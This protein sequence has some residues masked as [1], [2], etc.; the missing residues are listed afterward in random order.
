MRLIVGSFVLAATLGVEAAPC[1]GI[2]RALSHADAERLD[3]IVA[4]QLDTTS[5]DV[6]E[7]FRSGRWSVLHVATRVADPAYL[8]FDDDPARRHFVTMW[9]GAAAPFEKREILKWVKKNAPGIPDDL[10][11]CF[12]SR[13]SEHGA[14]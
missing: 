8:F 13:V 3:P 4:A 9:S 6:V 12:A 11:S 14:R 10:A 7:R 2:D 1:A 5:A